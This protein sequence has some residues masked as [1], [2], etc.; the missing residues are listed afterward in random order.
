[1]D[2][3]DFDLA[4]KFYAN[5]AK[6]VDEARAVF[7][8]PLTLAEKVI[9]SHMASWPSGVPDRGVTHLMLRPDR[10]AMQDAT[11]QMA[12][13]Q[14]MVTAQDT[15]AV[16]T[17]VH[18]DHLILAKK[19]AEKDLLS[20]IDENKEVYEFLRSACER[21]GLGFWKPGAG[22]IHQVVLEQ[23]AFPGG[24]MIGTDSHTPNAG[25]LGMVAIGVGGAD[26]VDVMAGEPWSVL[27]PKLIGIHLKGKLSGWASPKDIIL[28]VAGALTVNGGTGKIVEYFGEGAESISCTGKATIT[29]MGAELGA[30]TSIFPFDPH[31]AAYLRQ[32]ERSRLADL[33]E[34]N[35]GHLRPDSEV[36]ADPSKYY[37]QVLEIDLDTLKP[38]WVGPHTPDLLRP[39]SE[40]KAAVAKEGYP[41]EISCCLI[42]SCTNSS[43][44]DISRAAS[45]ARQA[46]D[47]G[48]KVKSSLLVTP[49]SDQVFKTI[50]RD[51]FI[52]LFTS[53][54]ATVLA[55]ACG[56]CIG[57]WTREDIKPGQ[58]NTI[59]TSYNRNFK[60]RND[61]NAETYAFVGSPETVTAMAFSGSLSFNPESDSLSDSAGK[62]FTFA[63]PQGDQLPKKGFVFSKEGFIA[64]MELAQ[65]KGF[66]I[67]IDPKSDRLSFLEVFDGWD[68]KDMTNLLVLV[69]ALGKCTTDHISQAGPWLKY[70]GHLENI[71]NNMLIGATNAF[72]SEIGK[73]TNQIT[74]EKGIAIPEVAKSYKSNK[75]GWVVIGDENYGEGSS[76]EHAAMSPRFL[77][78]RA[79]IVKSFA[80]IHETN[81][82]KQGVLP[83][84]FADPKDYDSIKEGDTVSIIGLEK[85]TPGVNLTLHITKADGGTLDIGLKHSLTDEHIKW[86]RAGSAL[87]TLRPASS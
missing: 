60:K 76:R 23:Y 59:V 65:R 58:R 62:S 27:N 21:Y 19:G 4:E 17:T 32:T 77:G 35:A 14:F 81:L 51:G 39:V 22:I 16:P 26:A 53:V 6:K 29:N 86:L 48:L 50:E 74:G 78:C 46:K 75:R 43:Y 25:G 57:Q 10:I 24:L 73:A 47:L 9:F 11:A 84:T 72:T 15:V 30:T 79:V 5:L 31:M 64:P 7:K 45:I 18:C 28:K 2:K 87:N 37:D 12:L 67:A 56:P 3:N 1:M 8:R 44:E 54:G 70:R 40:M 33:A 38:Q 80:R 42:G 82:K 69:K 71:S 55:N 63:V 85:I 13:L 61:G 49:G 83:L 52:D 68:G 41:D 20:A 66:S 34:A 36:L